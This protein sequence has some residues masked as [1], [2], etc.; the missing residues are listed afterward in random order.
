MKEETG[1]FSSTDGTQ[2]FYRAWNKNTDGCLIV[3][4]GIGEHSGRYKDFAEKL[5]D[6]PIS[7]FG[8]DLRGHGRS[9]GSRVYVR[10]FQDFIS[11]IYAYRQWIENRYQKQKFILLG[12]SLGGLISVST[13]LRDQAHWKALILMSPFFAVYKTH[14]ILNSLAAALACFIPNLIWKNPIKPSYLSHDLE[15][16]KKYKEDQLIQRAITARLACEMFRGCSLV[17]NQAREIQLP[18]LILAAGDDRIVSLK[19][20]QK[21]FKGISSTEKKMEVFERSYHELLHEKERDEAIL[22]IR[23][24]LNEVSS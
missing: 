8:F 6:L 14:G 15:E 24:F 13:V 17:Y 16:V 7:V 23:E 3:V 4:H 5:D 22:L 21:F 20:T 18:V 2:I 1:Y 9:E 11:D 10:S 19:A 12:Q